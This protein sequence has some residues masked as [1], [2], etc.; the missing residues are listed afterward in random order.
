MF[1]IAI[2]SRDEYIMEDGINTT[3]NLQ[4]ANVF[5]EPEDNDD[6][7]WPPTPEKVFELESRFA[8]QYPV[9][10]K[11]VLCETCAAVCKVGVLNYA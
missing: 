7:P 5:T 9:R 6:C 10:I 11:V 4:R 8:N 3:P 2:N 1:V